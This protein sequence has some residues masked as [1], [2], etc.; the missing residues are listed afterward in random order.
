M[1][2]NALPAVAFDFF[3]TLVDVDHDAP[4]MW[5]CLNAMGYQS[6]EAIQKIWESE[7]YNGSET[8]AANDDISYDVWRRHN[9][10]QMACM[11]GVPAENLH[12]VVERLLEIDQSWTVRAVPSA[13]ELLHALRTAGRSLAVC[14]NWDYPIEKYLKQA[15][16]PRV[17]VIVT[18]R[19]IGARKPH[20]R[21]FETV[22]AELNVTPESILFVGDNWECDVVGALRVGMVP[23]WIRRDSQAVP[24]GIKVLSFSS[25]HDMYKAYQEKQ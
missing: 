2:W 12:R 13:Q 20:Y 17:D 10:E 25:L 4:P 9:L 5:E 8:P 6:C 7:A 16:L 1:K 15:G 3:G 11:S 19:D 22:A 21:P 23:V 14:S 18:S 24:Q